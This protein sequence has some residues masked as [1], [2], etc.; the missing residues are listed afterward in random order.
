MLIVED[1]DLNSRGEREF[2]QAICA[3]DEISG[4]FLLYFN[5]RASDS[6]N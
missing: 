6:P 5:L 3:G 1:S 2:L 4:L